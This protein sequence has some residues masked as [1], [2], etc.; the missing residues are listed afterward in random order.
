MNREWDF[1]CNNMRDG[2]NTHEANIEGRISI[3]LFVSETGTPSETRVDPVPY[4]DF[5]DPMPQPV[6]YPV[7]SHL[8]RGH[9]R[10]RVKKTRS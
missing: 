2:Q 3:R 8:R 9:L 10:H 5:L 1:D 7:G 6:D 4:P